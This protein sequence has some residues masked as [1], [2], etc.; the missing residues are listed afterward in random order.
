MASIAFPSYA[1][2]SA[3]Q[4]AVIVASQA[5]FNALGGLGTWSFTPFPTAL[6]TA[7][8]D[9]SPVLT[10]TDI[11]LQQILVEQ[12]I[13]NQMLAIGL[14]VVDDPQTQIRPDIQANDV[15]LTT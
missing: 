4:G 3:G 8:I 13:T 10:A 6:V 14:N 5:A 12:R 15:G 2:N 7:P 9:T 1:Y 11:R